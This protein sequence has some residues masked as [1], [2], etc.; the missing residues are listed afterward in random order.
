MTGYNS[1]MNR[2]D[3]LAFAHRDWAALGRSKREFWVERFRREGSAPARHASRLLLEHARRLDA[4]VLT[5]AQHADDLAH[6]VV[7]RGRLDRAARA[8]AGR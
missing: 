2:E 6:H 5:E 3:L 4:S 1:M 7:L 8:L